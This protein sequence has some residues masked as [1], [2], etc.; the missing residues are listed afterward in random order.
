MMN[1]VISFNSQALDPL[2]RLLLE[3]SYEAFENGASNV[4]YPESFW[5]LTTAAGVRMEDIAGENVGV[6]IGTFGKDWWNVTAEDPDAIP[7]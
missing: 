5:P 2:Q 7:I 1:I 6:F 4:I 3:C